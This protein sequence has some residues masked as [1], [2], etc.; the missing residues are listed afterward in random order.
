MYVVTMTTNGGD[1]APVVISPQ[2]VVEEFTNAHT[3]RRQA[4]VGSEEPGHASGGS[5]DINRAADVVQGPRYVL[6]ISLGRDA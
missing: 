4:L 2:R 1:L 6:A 5:S 3:R